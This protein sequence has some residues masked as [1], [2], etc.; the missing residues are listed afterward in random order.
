MKTIT[1]SKQSFEHPYL[2]DGSYVVQNLNNPDLLFIDARGEDAIKNGTLKNAIVIDWRELS[3]VEK[4]IGE[5]GWGHILSAPVL[6]KKLG[7]FGLDKRKE[8]IIFSG[9]QEAWGEDGR[10]FWELRAVG[11]KNLK[12]VDGGI[13]SIL[14]A[15]AELTKN[16]DPPIPVFV[17][18]D[19]IDDT[20]IIDTSTLTYHR[21]EYAL[22]DARE[23]DE[24]DGAVKFGEAHGGHIPNAINIPFSQLF[25]PDYTLKSR[26]E[27]QNIFFEYGLRKMDPIVVYCTGGIRSAFMQLVLEMLDYPYVKSYQGS[28]YNWCTVN[29]VE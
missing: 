6:S 10:L 13:Q 25:D 15:G 11:Y 19:V 22:V 8:I 9:A 7:A 17:H 2:V 27:L 1:P 18:L 5:N 4:N 3:D 24:Y 12:M 14:R 20:Y 16:P 29:E 26:E 23:K 28:Y 21:S